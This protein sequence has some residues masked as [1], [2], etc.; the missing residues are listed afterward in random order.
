M[1]V[2]APAYLSEHCLVPALPA[3]RALHPGI[4]VELRAADRDNDPAARSAEVL[5]LYGW[6]DSRDWVRRRIAQTRM[7]VCAS[8]DYWRRHSP[9]RTPRALESHEC[10]LFRDQ[11]GTVLDLWTYERGDERETVAVRGWL[12]SSHRDDLLRAALDGHGVARLSDLTIQDHLRDGRLVPA[13]PGWDSRDAPPVNLLYRAGGRR[14]P[15]VRVFTA[16]VSQLFARL[17]AERQ[18]RAPAHLRAERP[19]WYRRRRGRASAVA[20]G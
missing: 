10:L 18:P 19:A 20:L 15:R 14:P 6:P 16:F 1:V 12:T 13:L 4:Q 11:E 2:A 3:F 5:L 7:L 9:P 8:P 17:E